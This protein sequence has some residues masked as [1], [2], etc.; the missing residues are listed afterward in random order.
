MSNA[1]PATSQ[2]INPNQTSLGDLITLIRSSTREN[3]NQHLSQFI[4]FLGPEI[5]PTFEHITG[6]PYTSEELGAILTDF[7]Q[8][9]TV[10]K[11][12][13]RYLHTLL[14]KLIF[15]LYSQGIEISD[16]ELLNEMRTYIKNI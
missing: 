7:Q 14:A 5:R 1:G 12:E 8:Q 11:L 6:S 13:I 3:Y 16:K 10:N 15:E 9:I 2:T 4:A